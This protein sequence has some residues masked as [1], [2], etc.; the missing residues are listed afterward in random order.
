MD[1]QEQQ[2]DAHY[3]KVRGSNEESRGGK[4][5]NIH[6]S[7]LL[8]VPQGCFSSSM[9]RNNSSK[10]Q[11]TKQLTYDDNYSINRTSYKR[12]QRHQNQLGGATIF[13]NKTKL[14]PQLAPTLSKDSEVLEVPIT[15][16]Q[17]HPYVQVYTNDTRFLSPEVYVM[18]QKA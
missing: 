1:Q 12:G 10:D 2:T 5:Q 6:S 18:M 13:Q 15:M 14:L 7:L 9:D 16:V 11:K 4:P 8:S 17:Y 3:R